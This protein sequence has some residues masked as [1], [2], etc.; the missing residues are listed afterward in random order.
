MSLIQEAL[1]RHTAETGRP[2]NLPPLTLPPP[3]LPPPP[4]TSPTS[5][6]QLALLVVVVLALLGYGGWWFFLRTPPPAVT[7]ARPPAK[8]SPPGQAALAPPH[9]NLVAQ[10]KAKLETMLT[11]E[12]RELVM[13]ETNA[14]LAGVPKLPPALAAVQQAPPS[15]TIAPPPAPT[16]ATPPAVINPPPP[17]APA[18]QVAPQHINWPKLNISGVMGRTGNYVIFINGQMLKV[19]DVIA[20]ARIIAVQENEAHLV[21]EGETNVF[22]VG[23]GSE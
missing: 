5:R 20:G 2:E 13:G 16:N 10:A 8:A 23:K 9:T 6:G 3:P 7:A 1:K 11:P 17:A 14:P 18:P 12:R 21:L 15:A 4:I 19:G 22:R